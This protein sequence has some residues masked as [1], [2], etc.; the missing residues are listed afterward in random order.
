MNV[1]EIN[2]E[3]KEVG[4][5]GESV[6]ESFHIGTFTSPATCTRLHDASK[7]GSEYSNSN[8]EKNAWER[9]NNVRVYLIPCPR[10]MKVMHRFSN[11]IYRYP[12]MINM[13]NLQHAFY[14]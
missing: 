13:G 1:D 6:P 12:I 5:R 8:L 14:L 7:F 9:T 3:G 4:K 11:I 10:E 2:I